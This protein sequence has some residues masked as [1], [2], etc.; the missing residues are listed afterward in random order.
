[1]TPTTLTLPL[2][3]RHLPRLSAL[4]GKLQAQTPADSEEKTLARI[5]LAGMAAMESA[6]GHQPI[7]APARVIDGRRNA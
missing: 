6:T 3:E 5:F 7:I 4:V 1:M 2:D